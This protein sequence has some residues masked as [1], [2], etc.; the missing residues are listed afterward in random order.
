MDTTCHNCNEI[1]KPEM[2]G[3]LGLLTGLMLVIL[4][5]C[6][7]CIMAFTGT[8]LLCGEGTII[9]SQITHNSTIT[10]VITALLCITT[11]AGII[12]NKRGGRTKYAIAMALA[13]MTMIMFSVVWDGG[14]TLYYVGILLVFLA[15]WLNG[16]MAWV[17]FQV[18]DGLKARYR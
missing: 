10:I 5:K 1:A 17:Y 8:A 9:E 18:R 3:K 6:P 16:S 11:L 15:V 14:Q 4:P 7:F 2:K 13:G 12:L